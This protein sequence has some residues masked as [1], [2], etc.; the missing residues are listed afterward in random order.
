VKNSTWH[1]RGI[2][3]VLVL[4]GCGTAQADD[5]V[6][7]LKVGEAAPEFQFAAAVG[8]DA[9]KTVNPMKVAADKPVLLIF[10]SDL[11]RQGFAL[12]KQLDKYGRLRQPEGLEVVI[13]RSAADRDEAARHAKLLYD[14][15][16]VKSL[17]GVAEEGKTGPKDYNLHEDAKITVLLVDR[18]HKVVFNQARRA[19][20]RQDFQETRDAIDKLLG[21]SP[22]AFP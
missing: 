4:I 17:A 22:V 7:G 16:D 18:K 21:P 2:L 13:V 12:L 20:D 15:Y 10:I 3:A 11:N 5:P 19:P 8:D 9:G 6:S 1:F 14:L